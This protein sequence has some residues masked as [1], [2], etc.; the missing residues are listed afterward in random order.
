MNLL[1]QQLLNGLVIGSTYAVVAIGFSLT[2]TVLRIV[3]FAHPELFM[4]GMFA[5]GFCASYVSDNIFVVFAAGALG[6]GFAGALMERVVLRPLR[7]R[8]V[9]MGLIGT[10]GVAFM[11][12]NGVAAMLGPD[13]IPYP[14]VIKHTLVLQG[15]V[16]LS[17]K[18]VSNLV[19]S[20]LLLAG[21]TWYV[22]GTRY[23]LASRALAER[24]DVAAAFGVNIHRVS[25]AT[26]F[27]SSAMAGLAAV[28][29]GVLYSTSYAFVGLLY[30]L[31]SFICMLVAGNRYFEGVI[32]VALLLGVVEALV[33]GYISSAYRDAAAFLLMILVLFFRPDGLFGSYFSGGDKP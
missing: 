15:D 2:F 20:V 16:L 33:V 18:Q 19:V 17:S 13:P 21:L 31:K 7:Q 10:L 23:G 11:L 8:D 6:A 30:G 1:L 32:V 27:I 14:Q 22:R 24:P 5:G 3:N 9:L 26:V 25:Q 12:S 29:I 4:I 28:S